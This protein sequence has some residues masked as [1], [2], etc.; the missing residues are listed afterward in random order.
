[1]QKITN[2]DVVLAVLDAETCAPP[3]HAVDILR[4]RFGVS[5]YGVQTAIETAENEGC[6][7]RSGLLNNPYCPIELTCEGRLLLR[8]KDPPMV[9]RWVAIA[10]IITVAIV[11]TPVVLLTLSI[12]RV[13]G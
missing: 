13:S 3:I 1:M 6:I 12:W 4:Q 2:R 9:S 5:W 8:L 11:M 7:T 10:I